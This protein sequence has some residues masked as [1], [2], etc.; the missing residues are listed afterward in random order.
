MSGSRR[1]LFP[2]ALGTLIA[3]VTLGVALQSL[4][5]VCLAQAPGVAADARKSGYAYMGRDTRA[6]QDDELS[7]PGMLAVLEGE[8]LWSRKPTDTSQTCAGCHGDARTSMRGVAARH[9]AF[10]ARLSR[11]VNLEQRINECRVRQQQAP[12][13][14]W[15]SRELLALSTFVA[16]QS[17]GLPIS[18]PADARMQVHVEAG[19]A[20]YQRRQG[21]LNLACVQCHDGLADRRLVGN[22]ITQGQATGYP[23]YRLE[24]QSVGSLQRRLR[25]C[26]TGVRAEPLAYGSEELVNLEAF[27]M[28]RARGMPMETP[29]VRP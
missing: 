12:A 22:P 11:P 13:L 21:Q 17:R 5:G 7:N 18:P 19:R 2:N 3:L 20:S 4:S 27:L 1:L 9:P 24:W 25:N 14:P 15:E 29:A 6:M 28:Q 23:I 26:M 8:A 16:H 10:E